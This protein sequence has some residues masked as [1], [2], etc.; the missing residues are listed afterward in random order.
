[1]GMPHPQGHILPGMGVLSHRRLRRH[2]RCASVRSPGGCS[3]VL[4]PSIRPFSSWRAVSPPT[5]SI[6]QAERGRGFCPAEGWG[7]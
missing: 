4:L 5:S 3:V 2:R 6:T 7:N 1:M